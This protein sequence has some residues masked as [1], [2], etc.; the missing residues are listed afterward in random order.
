MKVTAISTKAKNRLHNLMD[1]NPEVIVEQETET[2]FFVASI[3]RK[4]FFWMNKTNDS[5]WS[6]K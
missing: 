3:N 4:H 2:S 1:N 5:H 6:L